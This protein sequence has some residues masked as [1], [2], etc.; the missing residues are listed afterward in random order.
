MKRFPI[1]ESEAKRKLRELMGYEFLVEIDAKTLKA[2][3]EYNR[4]GSMT[5][6]AKTPDHIESV[7]IFDDYPKLGVIRER[8][9]NII[10][11]DDGR[12]RVNLAASRG[13]KIAVAVDQAGLDAILE[14]GLLSI[15]KVIPS[16]DLY[17]DLFKHLVAKTLTP[18]EAQAK[19]LEQVRKQVKKRLKEAKAQIAKDL[20]KAELVEN[21]KKRSNFEA[22]PEFISLITA[23]NSKIEAKVISNMGKPSL[24]NRTG[25][26]A[27]SVRLTRLV[28]EN[29]N[30]IVRYQYQ[31]S[32]YQVF[33]NSVL[34]AAPWN[35]V[36]ERD[37]RTIIEKSIRQLMQE[38]AI[39]KFRLVKE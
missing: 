35:L 29:G 36:P 19:S 7:K 14:S 3:V 21:R 5:T 23:L 26:F 34:G 17:E 27:S 9:R 33:E 30:L 16:A 4:P 25:R 12:T 20:R 24:V 2:A 38:Q 11:L 31:N 18:E 1:I 15:F 22:P 28:N 37:P 10:G 6:D 39:K 8:G 32:P 13:Q